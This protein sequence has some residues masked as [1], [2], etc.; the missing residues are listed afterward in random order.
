MD[1]LN[2]LFINDGIDTKIS[3]ISDKKNMKAASWETKLDEMALFIERNIFLVDD[4][5]HLNVKI[6]E[7]KPAKIDIIY[8]NDINT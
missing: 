5:F 1:K 6:N 8:D 4:F 2:K 3:V 7:E